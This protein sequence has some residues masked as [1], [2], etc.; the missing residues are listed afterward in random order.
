MAL[1]RVQDGA[2]ALI[3]GRHSWRALAPLWASCVSRLEYSIKLSSQKTKPVSEY[4]K[5]GVC[6]ANMARGIELFSLGSDG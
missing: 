3:G 5:K 1:A 6:I 2:S 4:H